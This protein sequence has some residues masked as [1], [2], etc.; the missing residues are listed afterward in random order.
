MKKCIIKE[1]IGQEDIA[2]RGVIEDI[3]R[4]G[5]RRMLQTAIENEVDEYI[6]AHENILDENGHRRVV[7]NGRLPQRELVTGI[8][9]IKV[10]QPRVN[11]KRK[12]DKFTSKILPPFMRRVPSIDTLIPCLYLKGI[13]TG[14]FVEALEAI[15]GPQAIGLSATNIVRLKDGW[16]DDYELW[17]KRDLSEKQYVY[18]WVDGIHFNVRLDNERSC[19]LV[20]IGATAEGKKELI[21]VYDGYRESKLSWQEVLRDVKAQGLKTFPKLVIGDGALGFWAAA[22]EEFPTTQVQ[23]CWVHKTANILDKMPKGVQG[24]AKKRIHDMYMAETKEQALQA[25]KEFLHLYGAKF[26]AACECLRKDKDGLFTFYD[27]P[28]EHWKHIRTTNPIESTFATVRLRTVRTKGCGS[29]IATLTMVY[30]LAEQAEKHWNKLN[31]SE[32]ITLVIQ[33]VEFIDG[34]IKKA[35]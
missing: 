23:R 11:D 7:R 25:Y 28:A 9:P 2:C 31:K 1:V 16:K 6:E 5:A 13:S 20:M 29:R 19:I 33:G 30:K 18:V 3:L 15:L 27:F 24:R 34:V 17:K 14:D 8:G 21:A 12:G 32:L 4:A 26:P 35:A 22:A 10:R